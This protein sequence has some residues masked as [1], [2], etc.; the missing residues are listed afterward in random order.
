MQLTRKG[1][2]KSL[3]AVAATGLFTGTTSSLLQAQEKVRVPAKATKIREVEIL[4]Y[5]IP[6]KLVIKVALPVALVADGVFIRLHTEDGLVGVGEAS[7]YSPVT[8]ET[9]LTDIAFAR[10]LAEMIKGRDPFTIP[11]IVDE[12]DILSPGNSSI[13]AAFEM[14]LWDLCGKLAGQ[15]VC[16]LL[17]KFRDSFE[18]DK[19]IGIDTPQVMAEAARGVKQDGFRTIK[20]KVGESP[21]IDIERLQAVRQAVGDG[22]ALR[23]DANQAWTPTEAVQGLRGIE[24]FQVQLCEQPVPYWNIEGLKFIRDRSSIPI[25]AD[26]AVHAPHNVVELIRRD[27]VDFVNIKLMKSGGILNAVRTAQVADAAGIRCMLGCMTETSLALTA[28]A[29]VI[30]SQ[31]NVVYADLD[32]FLYNS[33]NPILGGIEIRQGV[34]HL[35]S[36]PGLGL[37]IDPDY[38]KKLTPA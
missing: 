37:E 19:T 26:E 23:I 30:A 27:A 4:P 20:V 1:F 29:H 15:P 18:T 2:F 6:V 13:K 3:G 12:M 10:T 7:P 28:A 38:L 24:K 35:P 32:S 14:A 34:V 16:C 9:K 31:K 8:G 22:I 33:I 25:M 17:G 21:A 36:G 5:S 11:K